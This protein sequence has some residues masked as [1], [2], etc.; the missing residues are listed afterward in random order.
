MSHA[1]PSQGRMEVA[2]GVPREGKRQTLATA[3]GEG[4]TG[5]LPCQPL[6]QPRPSPPPPLL[7]S[8]HSSMQT[9]LPAACKGPPPCVGGCRVAQQHVPPAPAT[10]P[11]WGALSWRCGDT[12]SC[13][14][15]VWTRAVSPPRV[16]RAPPHAVEAAEGVNMV[17]GSVLASSP[18]G[19][20]RVGCTRGWGAPA[21]G[22]VTANA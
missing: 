13:T 21:L 22:R 1:T 11:P 9:P 14:S 18:G 19:P 17:D 15:R 4:A 16:S 6:P 5:T 3:G 20:P 12:T 10:S 2:E 7:R 8:V